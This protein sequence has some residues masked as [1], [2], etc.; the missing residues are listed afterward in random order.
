MSKNFVEVKL[1]PVK[2]DAYR[3]LL[4]K[5]LSDCF[6]EELKTDMQ[7]EYSEDAIKSKIIFS[8]DG[9]KPFGG[10]LERCEYSVHKYDELPEFWG[11]SKSSGYNH[12]MNQHFDGC[13]IL[14]ALGRIKEFG[15]GGQQNNERVCWT[16]I[17]FR[18]ETWE[19]INEAN[20][21][22]W[23]YKNFGYMSLHSNGV[24]LRRRFVLIHPNSVFYNEALRYCND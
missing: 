11:L 1:K 17:R 3:L 14:T 18:Q 12:A 21:C 13:I 16:G 8:P 2:A 9:V 20:P 5:N 6:K 22:E 19:K 23:R 7:L 10:K 4:D 15:W 24:Y